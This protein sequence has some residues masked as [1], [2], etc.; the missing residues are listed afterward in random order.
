MNSVP[1]LPRIASAPLGLREVLAREVRVGPRHGRDLTPHLDAREDQLR[2]ERL[3]PEPAG[4]AVCGGHPGV[5]SHRRGQGRHLVARVQETPEGGDADVALLD[6]ERSPAA[7]D[8]VG[9]PL[10]QAGEVV[11]S[12]ATGLVLRA[13]RRIAANL[14]VVRLRVPQEVAR[15][16]RAE[17][18]RAVNA[19][20]MAPGVDHRRA[21]AGALADEVDLVVPEGLARR[22]EVV[23]PLGQRVAR[24]VEA[25]VLEAL[26][27]DLY[28]AAWSRS[29]S[30]ARKSLE[31]RIAFATSGQSRMAE[32]STPR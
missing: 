21:G 25:L 31:R 11:G 24:E 8:V 17:H 26:A 22:L 1:G 30:L 4:V 29:E 16:V 32:P 14:P 27:H 9:F 23:Y 20:R 12:L 18:H 6:L 28:P 5:Q 19:V 15:R 13:E 3:E 10:D 2:E 7:R